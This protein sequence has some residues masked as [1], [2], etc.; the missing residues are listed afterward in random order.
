MAVATELRGFDLGLSGFMVRRLL[1]K[2]LGGVL[3]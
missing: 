3:R 1:A 2:D